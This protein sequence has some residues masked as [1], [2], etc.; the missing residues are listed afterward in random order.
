MSDILDPSGPF[1]A[2][3]GS[4]NP[5]HQKITTTEQQASLFAKFFV[6]T[7]N[8]PLTHITEHSSRMSAE[9]FLATQTPDF[10]LSMKVNPSSSRDALFMDQIAPELFAHLQF[11][12]QR[13]PYRFRPKYSHTP[14]LHLKNQY[15]LSQ[16]FFQRQNLYIFMSPFFQIHSKHWLRHIHISITLETYCNRRQQT[17]TITIKSTTSSLCFTFLLSRNNNNNRQP[18]FH[19][20]NKIMYLHH[21]FT[22]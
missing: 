16:H 7:L 4:L 1:F 18:L 19:Q 2:I 8:L 15:A 10:A 22:H 3:C 12:R 5:D 9:M 13:Q 20:Q 21:R 14:I 6:R 11:A 17:R